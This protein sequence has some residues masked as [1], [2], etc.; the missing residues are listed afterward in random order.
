MPARTSPRSILRFD[1][2][3]RFEIFYALRA[4]GET[5][6]ANADWKERTARLL[7]ANF[8][9]SIER[10]APRPII[11]ALLA[12]TLRDAKAAPDFTEI[13]SAIESLDDTSFQ[14]AVLKGVFR[15]SGTV[16]ALI[17]GEQSLPDAVRNESE[18][19]STLLSLIGLEP[20]D[21]S[22]AEAGAFHRIVSEPKAYR[23]EVAGALEV[24]WE[25][26]FKDNWDLLA[27]RM[28]RVVR[29]MQST[30]E[31]SSMSVF[32][33]EIRLPVAFD[34][35]KKA[36]ISLRGA[37]MFSYQA[38]REIHV[39]PSAFNNS[40]FW[41]AYT[42]ENTSSVRLYF[43][44]FNPGLLES[45]AEV[46]N[47]ALG[48]RA[49]GDTT[50]YAMAFLLAQSPQTSAELAKAF[51]V[52]K[53]T[54]SHHVHLLRSAGLL[55]ERSTDKGIV[56]SLNRGALERISTLA[57]GEMFASGSAPVIRRSRREGKSRQQK[58]SAGTTL[59]QSSGAD[60]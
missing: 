40:R 42:D 4:L 10:V 7:P 6:E 41:G 9:N 52:S 55:D 51:S 38:V 2:T 50:R 43:P 14:L 59:K 15:R 18:G 25:S 36:V 54:I 12:D 60:E 56:L 37:T 35:R 47:P 8:L 48:F 24:F 13:L 17:A 16:L 29:L 27:P 19:G 53:A 5:T 44:V 28:Q 26:T 49:L 30:L 58:V 57:A 33:R 31:V 34:D 21:R 32:A 11:W 3:P 46:A 1:V 20:F 45:D 39:I 22:S 23:S